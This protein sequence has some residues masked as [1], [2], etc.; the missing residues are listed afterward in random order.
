MKKKNKSR[1]D[2]VGGLFFVG[3]LIMGTGIG[4][5][6]GNVSAGTLIGLG[7]GFLLFGIIKAFMKK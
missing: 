5:L 2:N 7:V 4:L 3:A 6:Y 1:S